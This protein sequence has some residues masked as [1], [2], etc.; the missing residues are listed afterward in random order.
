M[1]W[2]KNSEVALGVKTR[3][4]KAYKHIDFLDIF[5]LFNVKVLGG[6][7]F[8]EEPVAETQTWRAFYFFHQLDIFW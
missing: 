6:C 2:F 1:F 5:Q 4:I 7:Y 8:F 3:S